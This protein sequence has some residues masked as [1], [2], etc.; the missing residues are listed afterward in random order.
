MDLWTPGQP[1]DRSG[2]NE[3]TLE[4]MSGYGWINYMD[5]WINPTLAKQGILYRIYSTSDKQATGWQ[6]SLTGGIEV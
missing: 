5:A 3:T 1:K 4:Y 6:I 2:G